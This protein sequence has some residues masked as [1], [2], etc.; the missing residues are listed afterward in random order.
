MVDGSQFS[1]YSTLDQIGVKSEDFGELDQIG[2][3]DNWTVF[4]CILKM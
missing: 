3:F 2:Y 4:L 1:K